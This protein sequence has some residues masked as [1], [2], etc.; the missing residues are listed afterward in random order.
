MTET[1]PAGPETAPLSEVKAAL[2][3]FLNEFNEFQDDLN[4][5]LQK[6]EERIAMLSTKTM[7]HLRPALSTEADASAPH[8]KAMET[9]LRCGEDDALRGLELEGK[10]LNTAVN[11]EGGYLVDP[12]TAESIQSVLRSA[13]SLRAIA[14]VV[15][16][17]AT[18]F[19]V[20]IDRPMSARAGR[21]R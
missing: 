10:A 2:S 13:S 16:V 7:T 19:D 5:K 15:T 11:A 17:E 12:Q 1:D 21:T 18:S 8:R 3:G 14:S 9:Y 20:L 6:Q 4:V